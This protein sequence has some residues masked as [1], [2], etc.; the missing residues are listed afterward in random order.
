M[1]RTKSYSENPNP[2]KKVKKTKELDS[3]V[4]KKDL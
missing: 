1:M 3:V 2:N 4:I